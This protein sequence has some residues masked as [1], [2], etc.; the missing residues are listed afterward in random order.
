[1][2]DHTADLDAERAVLG[3]MLISADARQDAAEI[4]TG[5]DFY[6]LAHEHIYR[7][8]VSQDESG[9]PVDPITIAARLTQAGQL[10]QVG[11]PLYLHDLVSTVTVT[12]NVTHWA[13]I[14]HD[15]ATR[16]SIIDRTLK[17]QQIAHDPSLPAAELVER[18]RGLFDETAPVRAEVT[19]FADL[20]D[21]VIDEMDRGASRGI[22]TPWADLDDL[23]SGWQPDRLYVIAA[24]PAVGKSIAAQTIATDLALHHRLDV[25]FV[26]LE[27]SRRE[28][29]RRALASAA[30][31][32][33]TDIIR[34]QLAEEQWVK[35][36][37]AASRVKAQTV[38]INDDPTQ[39]VPSIR[40]QART[41]ARG[42]RLGMVV[43][44]HLG[45]VT[46]ED[47]RISR[48]QQIGSITRGL[49]KL[50]KELHVPVVALSQLNR[51][52]ESGHD[53]RRPTLTDLRDSGDI[54]QDADIVMF[55]HPPDPDR[56]PTALV[57]LVAKNR[58]GA[59]GEVPLVRQGQFA[60]LLPATH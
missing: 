10:D 50:A 57:G 55:L 51:A 27:M 7:A 37:K 31:V 16:R 53:R 44:D 1:M 39:T 29:T 26:A 25:L 33:L 13:G 42:G 47:A 17:A 18:V 2:T 6:R 40:S 28:L 3:A 20:V 8:I 24:R 35:L 4:L 46:P 30:K 48:T 34:G 5:P 41:L 43:V 49:K 38:F 59:L 21:L 15:S 52:S 36:S 32:N 23:I 22:P 45:L 9:E 56:N 58:D 19:S 12:A 11:G 60:R 54:E 14:I